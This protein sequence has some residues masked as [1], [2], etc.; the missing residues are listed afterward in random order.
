[1]GPRPGGNRF[2]LRMVRRTLTFLRTILIMSKW[3]NWPAIRSAGRDRR[4]NIVSVRD[5]S[6][7]RGISRRAV[8]AAGAA[9]ALVPGPLRAVTPL[10]VV[11]TT[12][13]LADTVREIGGDAVEVRALMGPG[14]DPHSYRQTRT[15]ILAM[16]RADLI[17]A[18]GLYLEAQMEDILA[19]FA[20]AARCSSPPRRCRRPA[21]RPRRLRGQVRPP[22]LDGPRTLGAWS[23]GRSATR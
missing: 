17:V 10:Q 15:D 12:G 3:I 5:A 4:V 1:M 9:A 16:S 8:L 22:C 23:S 7:A 18:N 20:G 13:M 6:E 2:S 14:V 19:D 11:A 21:L